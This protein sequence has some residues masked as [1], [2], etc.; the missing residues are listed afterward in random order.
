MST[1]FGLPWNIVASCISRRMKEITQAEQR[2]DSNL[3]PY[4]VGAAPHFQGAEL[5]RVC[6]LVQALATCS[7]QLPF[8]VLAP[9]FSVNLISRH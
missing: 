1:V 5:G 7:M 9:G 3:F 2:D 6:N 8:L 4:E